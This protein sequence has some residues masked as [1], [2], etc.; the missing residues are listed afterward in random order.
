VGET[1]ATMVTGSAES[2]SGL[3]LA[4]KVLKMRDEDP[5]ARQPEVVPP[6]VAWAVQAARL[7][8][9]IRTLPAANRVDHIGS[10]AIP[11]M[12]AKDVIDL[13]VSVADLAAADSFNEPLATL[14][15]ARFPYAQD[16]VPAGRQDAPGLWAKR[17]WVRRGHSD[18]DVNLHVRRSGN[19]NER[20]AL[21][22]RD[23]FRAH[24]EAVSAYSQFKALLA[25]VCADVDQYADIKDPVV[26]IV[27]VAAEDWARTT[28]WEVDSHR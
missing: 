14:G 8:D 16:H 28:G 23:W 20:L 24:P 27:A 10:T 3:C 11:G 7:C 15:F 19:P 5:F 17:F 2:I 22:F 13:Q 25:G 4:S 12:A 1:L 9:A 18:G 26:D 21:L 6:K